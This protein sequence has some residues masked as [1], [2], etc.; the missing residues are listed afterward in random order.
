MSV[1]YR[2]NVFS[3]TLFIP[4]QQDL[5]YLFLEPKDFM[6]A[7]SVTDFPIRDKEERTPIKMEHEYERNYSS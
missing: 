7:V 2:Q 6:E 4:K 3:H 1:S 5:L